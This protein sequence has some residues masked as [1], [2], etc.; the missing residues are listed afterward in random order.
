MTAVAP[1][2]VKAAATVVVPVT[3]EV[4]IV[5]VVEMTAFIVLTMI[6]VTVFMAFMVFV[7]SCRFH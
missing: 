5:F 6:E 3:T 4:I 2:T 1:I 7:R